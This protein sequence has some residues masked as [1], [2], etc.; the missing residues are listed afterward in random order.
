[1]QPFQWLTALIAKKTL[2]LSVLK[3]LYFWEGKRAIITQIAPY[4]MVHQLV[5]NLLMM[6]LFL[7]YVVLLN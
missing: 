4:L 3:L 5:V 1:M 6:L 7:G 2:F